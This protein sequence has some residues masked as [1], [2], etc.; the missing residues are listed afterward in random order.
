MPSNQVSQIGRRH[1]DFTFRHGILLGCLLAT[2]SMPVG[3][4]QPAKAHAKE[5]FTYKNV[6]DLEIKADVYR[7]TGAG[8]H[9]AIIWIH[10][11]G[12]IF[13]SRTTIPADE[14]DLFLRAGYIVVSI[15][16]RLAPETKIP[17]I[18][19]DVGDA[20]RWVREKGPGLFQCDPEHLAIVG[21]SGGAYLALMSGVQLHPSPK[22]I[23]SFY[24]Y[25]DIAGPWLAQPAIYWAQAPSQPRVTKEAALQAISP[26]EIAEADVE[27]RVNFY[28]YC[29][30]NGL[31]PKEVAGFD[32]LKEREKLI[33]YSP[34]R[35]V[36][37]GYPPTLLLH[38][39]RDTDVPFQLS[40]QMAAALQHQH[41]EH[42]LY[43]MR[44]FNHLFDVYPEGLPP[45]G[46]AI[47]LQ[48]PQAAAAF[49]AALLFIAKHIGSEVPN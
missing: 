30:Q 42:S 9:P 33:A 40:E 39:D 41:I 10:G 28:I 5:T 6:G 48:N 14:N 8:P 45:A 4:A 17:A 47:G 36:K 37:P 23:V 26:N 7:P 27:P 32:P 21:Q 22:V 25:G 16:Y 13:G 11:G 15:D 46:K 3:Q 18:L 29:R 19:E 34:D 12:L 20:Y 44:G 43:R 35:L 38:G 31:W 49:Q 24:G 1:T 2:A